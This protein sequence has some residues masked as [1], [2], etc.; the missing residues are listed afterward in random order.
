MPNKE[1]VSATD[2]QC[3]L[4]I[5]HGIV[6]PLKYWSPELPLNSVLGAESEA[7]A[8]DSRLRLVSGIYT[9]E[10]RLKTCKHFCSTSVTPEPDMPRLV[11]RCD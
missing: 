4:A 6:Y 7:F 8:N 11:V 1:T 3:A 5:W 10:P 9:T 2:R